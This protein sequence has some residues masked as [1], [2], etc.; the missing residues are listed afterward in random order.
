MSTESQALPDFVNPID[1][2]K[3][4]QNP[5]LLPYAHTVGSAIIKPIDK[6]RTKGNAMQAMYEQT[7]RQLDQIRKQV[8]LLMAQ[9][10]GIHD[11]V[12]ISERIYKADMN[13]KPVIGHTYH[14][15]ERKKDGKDVLSMVSP[16][17][18]GANS[19]FI[20]Q[21]TLHLLADHTWEIT[22]QAEPD[23]A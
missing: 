19:P 12:T 22:A 8:E 9:A 16:E 18:W 2:T 11:R 21:A 3:T 20:W 23:E 14:L 13:F 6:G 5:G 7:N 1:V 10:Q 4:A 17:E 15:Y